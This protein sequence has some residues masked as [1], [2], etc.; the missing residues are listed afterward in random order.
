MDALRS[1]AAKPTAEQMGHRVDLPDAMREKMESAFGADLSSVR[2]YES[3]TVADAGANAV[4]QGSDIAFAP[5]MLDFSSYGGQALLGHEISHVVSQA[6]GEVRGGGFLNDHSL[7]ARADREGAMAAAGQ[8]VAMPAAAMSSA[9]AAP[10]AGPMQANKSTKRLINAK[11]LTPKMINKA[12]MEDLQSYALQERVLRDFNTEMSGAL[13]DQEAGGANRSDALAATWGSG[14]QGPAMQV[15]NAMLGRL[16]APHMEAIENNAA[17]KAPQAQM[18]YAT[19]RLGE[20]VQNDEHLRHMIAGAKPA[21]EDSSYFQYD[22]DDGDKSELLMN[23]FLQQAAAPH[24]AARAA[25]MAKSKN[26]AVV[27]RGDFISSLGKRLSKASG[28][29]VFA[30]SLQPQGTEDD[31]LEDFAGDRGMRTLLGQ[32]RGLWDSPDLFS[33]QGIAT[34][35]DRHLR[36]RPRP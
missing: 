18:D 12:S 33:G 5:G 24:A 13:A 3:Q 25:T 2:L 31:Q 16:A 9:S 22:A 1:G 19:G 7:E 35:Q 6:R 4:A 10:A 21:F 14:N 15:Y 28:Q 17:Y 34:L 29:N 32:A 30:Q 36:R 23:N 20:A 8:T 11:R 26:E 27:R